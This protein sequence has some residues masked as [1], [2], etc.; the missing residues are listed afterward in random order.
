MSNQDEDR[1]DYQQQLEERE[2]WEQDLAA[3]AEYKE[4]ID[5][6]TGEQ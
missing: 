1:Y 6:I 3:Q 5:S 4:W 2:K